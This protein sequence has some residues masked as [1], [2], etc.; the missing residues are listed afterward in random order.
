MIEEGYVEHIFSFL[1]EGGIFREHLLNLADSTRRG[2]IIERGA[3]CSIALRTQ[4]H[5]G[6][7]GQT[8]EE[9]Y[10]MSL[11]SQCLSLTRDPK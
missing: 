6:L 7:P 8:S 4:V 2:G 5:F 1:I 3:I 10:V 11:R 9:G